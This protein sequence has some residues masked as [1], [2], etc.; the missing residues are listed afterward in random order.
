MRKLYRAVALGLALAVAGAT[1]FAQQPLSD[2]FI[3]KFRGTLSGR[4]GRTDGEF[5][6]VIQ[7]T[8]AGFAV[9]WPP[10]V[11]ANLEPA[12]RPGVFRTG[13]KSHFLE[14]DP[15]YWARLEGETLVVYAAQ[16]GEHGGY[17]IDSFL[18][19]VSGDGLDLVV[20]Q[21]AGGAEPRILNG[22]LARYG[23]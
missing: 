17:R 10:R 13:H 9:S 23:D 1:A 7:R 12:D 20:R 11:T 18:Y 16:I 8:G 6:V 21:L 5:T 4:D 22:R 14:G 2:G 19:T 3:G 15:V